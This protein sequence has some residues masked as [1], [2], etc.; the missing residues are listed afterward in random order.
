[1]Q[2]RVP[3]AVPWETL[4]QIQSMSISHSPQSPRNSLPVLLQP[5]RLPVPRPYRLP[6]QPDPI[7]PFILLAKK[8]IPSPSLPAAQ[9][10]PDLQPDPSGPLRS[11]FRSLASAV[12]ML[13]MSNLHHPDCKFIIFNGIYN[14]IPALAQTISFLSG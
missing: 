5:P 11:L 1:M 13:T 10:N 7:F 8:Q 9:S 14:T 3:A 6:P 4:V 12:Y 2:S